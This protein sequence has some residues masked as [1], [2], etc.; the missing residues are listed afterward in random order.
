MRLR[1]AE[2]Q[3]VNKIMMKDEILLWFVANIVLLSPVILLGLCLWW[4]NRS[5]SKAES[6]KNMKYKLLFQLRRIIIF[7]IT[8]TGLFW[9]KFIY[10]MVNEVIK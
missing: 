9:L 4:I 5:V 1:N 3:V 8:L 6:K 7:A 10:D 2:K